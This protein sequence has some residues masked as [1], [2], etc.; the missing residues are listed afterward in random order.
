[1]VHRLHTI[2]QRVHNAGVFEHTDSAAGKK[3][4]GSRGKD[5]LKLKYQVGTAQK[6][7]VGA[8]VFVDD[9]RLTSLYKVTAHCHN[10]IISRCLPFNLLKLIFMSIVERIVF[11]NH[12]CDLHILMLL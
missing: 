3:L 9:G 10:D 7:H 2:A 11:G 1:M 8:L 6:R 12:T 5:R 4:S